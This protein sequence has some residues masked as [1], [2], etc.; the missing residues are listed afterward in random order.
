MPVDHCI[1]SLLLS[2]IAG[3]SRQSSIA[4]PIAYRVPHREGVIALTFILSLCGSLDLCGFFMVNRKTPGPFRH[5]HRQHLTLRTRR[6]VLPWGL[7]AALTH[8]AQRVICRAYCASG[9]YWVG[10]VPP[11]AMPAADRRPWPRG[12]SSDPPATS[13]RQGLC[14]G[15][16][17]LDTGPDSHGKGYCCGHEIPHAYFIPPIA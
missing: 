8:T 11:G 17:R 5:L 13:K 9:G 7:D 1:P 3:L 15:Q 14:S 16:N 2:H 4:R 6:I 12:S 10:T